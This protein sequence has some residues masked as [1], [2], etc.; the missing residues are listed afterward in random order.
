MKIVSLIILV[1]LAAALFT[2][3]LIMLVR[4]II[5]DSKAYE[6]AVNKIES[7]H[8]VLEAVGRIDKFGY[9]PIGN[10]SIRNGY[11]QASWRIKVIG[12]N[13]SVYVRIHLTKE[14]QDDWMVRDMTI[15]KMITR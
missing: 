10:F 9:M 3:S 1:I 14:K 15:E 7:S 4:G 12:L 13:K 5:I 2:L 8:Q 11:G 6:T